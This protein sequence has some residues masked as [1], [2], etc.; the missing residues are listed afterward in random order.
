MRLGAPLDEHTTARE[1]E[2]VEARRVVDVSVFAPHTRRQLGIGHDA[3][4]FAAGVADGLQMGANARAA[5]V[6]RGLAELARLGVAAGAHPLTFAGLAGLGDLLVTSSSPRSRNYQVGLRLAAGER[7]PVIAE[8]LGHV[9]EGVPTTRV[10]RHLA[11]RY[12][13]RTPIIDRAYEVLFEGRPVAEALEEL[14]TSVPRDELAEPRQG[15]E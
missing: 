10:A 5:L 11:A 6:T 8:R 9:A 12:G 15:A 7:W 3:P 13:V 1:G 2:R 4:A 14:V